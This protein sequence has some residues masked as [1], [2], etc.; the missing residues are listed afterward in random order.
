[1]SKVERSYSKGINMCVLFGG[2]KRRARKLSK[3]SK[4]RIPARKAARLYKDALVFRQF[5]EGFNN[6]LIYGLHPS[7]VV[8]DEVQLS[9][10]DYRELEM[11][12]LNWHLTH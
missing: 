11:R 10:V 2:G 9:E 6:T 12:V 3:M 7:L 8:H 4:G 5:V 1:M